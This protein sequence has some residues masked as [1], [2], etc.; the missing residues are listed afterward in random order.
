MSH[1]FPHI[2]VNHTRQSVFRQIR[3][4]KTISV[5]HLFSPLLSN[6][7]TGFPERRFLSCASRRLPADRMQCYPENISL[8]CQQPGF[9]G[10][11]RKAQCRYYWNCGIP[12]AYIS[13]NRSARQYFCPLRTARSPLQILQNN[14]R[15]P[16]CNGWH[17][18]RSS[19]WPLLFHFSLYTIQA[20][21]ILFP[22][23]LYRKKVCWFLL[24]VSQCL[25]IFHLPINL[26]PDN[27]RKAD[28]KKQSRYASHHR[29]NCHY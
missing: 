24:S 8:C 1:P 17:N 15:L 16:R 14:G 7:H 9:P 27:P 11:A 25:M 4:G 12:R 13:W 28:S 21:E 20:G 3:S 19:P 2:P 10:S 6:P 26:P 22:G 29:I 18:T 5:G 23:L